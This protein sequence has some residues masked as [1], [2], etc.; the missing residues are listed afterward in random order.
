VTGRR[1]RRRKKLLVDFSKEGIP[2]TERGS[3][4]SHYVE[5]SVWKGLLTHRK[6]EWINRRPAAN[7]HNSHFKT[8]TRT[9]PATEGVVQLQCVRIHLVRISTKKLAVVTA[10][11]S[12]F[13]SNP[14]GK[15]LVSTAITWWLN[16]PNSF[17]NHQLHCSLALYVLRCL[18]HS[19]ITTSHFTPTMSALYKQLFMTLSDPVVNLRMYCKL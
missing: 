9:M 11:V 17:P 18:Q 2:V 12:W 7:R 8:L 19:K 4:R 10:G 16:S 5:K 1:R 14:V 6:N 3:T 15:F 13:F